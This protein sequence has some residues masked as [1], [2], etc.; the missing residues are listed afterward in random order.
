M[1]AGD[2]EKCVTNF[3]GSHASW[4]EVKVVD[5]LDPVDPGTDPGGN[6]WSATKVYNAGGQVTHYGATYE[7]KWWTQGDDPANGGPWKLLTGDPT[8]PVVTDP[9]P[10]DPVPVEP[11]PLE[12]PVVVDPSVFITWQAGVSQVSNGDKVTHNGKCFVAK[13]GP[14]VWESP[15]QSNW[16]WDEISCQ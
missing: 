7:A 11:T 8:P 13:N 15:V 2:Y 1:V 10:V 16:F 9:S 3:Y 14:G 4:P 12:P 5:K 6:G